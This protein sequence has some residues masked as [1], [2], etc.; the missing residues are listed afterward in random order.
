MTEEDEEGSDED[1]PSEAA[2]GNAAAIDVAE[3]KGLG[4]TADRLRGGMDI[5]E[6]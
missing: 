6:A 3:S 4:S 2:I 5:I 1:K